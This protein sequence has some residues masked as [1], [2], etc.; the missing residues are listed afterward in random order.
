[1]I[2]VATLSCRMFRKKT[3]TVKLKHI[4]SNVSLSAVTSDYHEEAEDHE[5]ISDNRYAPI[6]VNLKLKVSSDYSHSYASVHPIRQ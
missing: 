5:E 2:V 1:M 4:A 6:G 3:Q